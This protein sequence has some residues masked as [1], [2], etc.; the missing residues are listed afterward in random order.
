MRRV[1]LVTLPLL[2]VACHN[3]PDRSL[4]GAIDNGGSGSA[5]PAHP[6]PA[7]RAVALDD[8]ML[9]GTQS[10]H[11]SGQVWVLAES[12]SALTQYRVQESVGGGPFI[13]TTTAVTLVDGNTVRVP[14]AA[15]SNWTGKLFAVTP[16]QP[17]AATRLRVAAYDGTRGTLVWSNEIELDL[18]VVG[19][20][21]AVTLSQP[22][23]GASPQAAPQLPAAPGTI[24]FLSTSNAVTS[25]LVVLVNE[26]GEHH[27]M[28]EE[29]TSTQHTIGSAGAVSYE[30]GVAPLPS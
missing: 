16:T 4:I 23:T 26:R 3:R 30:R 15:G 1:L 7:F 20:P 22:P 5:G 12:R 10:P 14:T 19:N 2:A 27:S 6:R 8:R 11:A 25:Y 18:S 17:A 24:D 21:A 13:D 29:Q 9:F 28:V